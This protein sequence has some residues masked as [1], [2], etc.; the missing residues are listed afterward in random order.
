M[1]TAPSVIRGIV[2]LVVVGGMVVV[3]V[4]VVVL[5]VVVGGIVVVVVVVVVVLVVG[6]TV[7]VVVVVAK[8]PG[9]KVHP[10]SNGPSAI[11]ARHALRHLVAI[12]PTVPPPLPGRTAPSSE[13]PSQGR[14]K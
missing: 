5:E 1:I 2:V 10:P 8:R 6:A 3:D 7:D 13:M 14:Q 4:V 9:P 11:T 12:G